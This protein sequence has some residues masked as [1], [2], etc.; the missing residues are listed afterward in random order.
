MADNY[1][2]LWEELDAQRQIITVEKNNV[3]DEKPDDTKQPI[4]VG[5]RLPRLKK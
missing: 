4:F 2:F 5:R 3:A 1:R